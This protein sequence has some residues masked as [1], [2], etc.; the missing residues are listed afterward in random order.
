MDGSEYVDISAT[1]VAQFHMCGLM[2]TITTFEMV[3]SY[4]GT[5]PAVHTWL[6][7]SLTSRYD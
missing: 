1:S 5:T 6:M 7:L 4:Y 2:E 3:C